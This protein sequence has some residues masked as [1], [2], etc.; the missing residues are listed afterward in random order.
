MLEGN[1]FIR[2]NNKRLGVKN[3]NNNQRTEK[4]HTS[5]GRGREGGMD[6]SLVAV[7]ISAR[8]LTICFCSCIQEWPRCVAVSKGSSYS[9]LLVVVLAAAS[10]LYW[11]SDYLSTMERNQSLSSAYIQVRLNHANGHEWFNWVAK[12]TYEFNHLQLFLR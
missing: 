5:M 1:S 7:L 6:H 4:H 2:P 11:W 9:T 3:K 12:I 10:Q 8:V